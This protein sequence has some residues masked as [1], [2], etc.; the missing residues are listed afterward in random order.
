MEFDKVTRF[1]VIDTNGRSYV[2]YGVESIKI[3]SQ[4][5][6]RTLKI[7]LIGEKPSISITAEMVRKLRDE[8]N[9]TMTDCKLSLCQTNCDHDKAKEL[10][11]SNALR[12][13]N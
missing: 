9:E 12:R 1:E 13:R 5:N 3:V 7:F 11:K 6:G 2:R 4:D 10:L 8:T